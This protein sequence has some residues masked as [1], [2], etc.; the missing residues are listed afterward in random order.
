MNRVGFQVVLVVKNPPANAG[1]KRCLFNPRVGKIPWSRAWQPTPV[2]LPG[3]FH[4]GA[5][6]ATVHRVR[7]SGHNRNNTHACGNRSPLM[8]CWYMFKGFKGKK[9]TKTKTKP[10]Q[11]NKKKAPTALWGPQLW[12]FLL[13]IVRILSPQHMRAA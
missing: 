11:A 4:G 3:E 13:F 5:R 10:K 12:H 7:K 8:A 9:E 6:W 1:D 2:F